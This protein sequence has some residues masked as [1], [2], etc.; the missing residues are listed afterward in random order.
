M[1]FHTEGDAT[2]VDFQMA[3]NPRGAMKLLGP[4]INRPVQ[5]AND[6][7]MTKFK[8]LVEGGAA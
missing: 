5:K 3:M 7:H 6:G 2:R 1:S 8:H 4:L